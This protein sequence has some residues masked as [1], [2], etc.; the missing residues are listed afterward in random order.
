MPITRIG[1][2]AASTSMMSNSV[3]AVERVEFDLAVAPDLRLDGVHLARREHPRHQPAIGGVARRIVEDHHARRHLDV[4]LDQ[5]EDRAVARDQPA[6]ILQRRLDVVPTRD[7]PE[8]VLLVVVERLLVAHPLPHGIRI[9]VDLEV[10]RV[11]V[12]VGGRRGHVRNPPRS[13]WLG[14]GTGGR[15]P[16]PWR[17]A[18]RRDAPASTISSSSSVS[19][20]TS[21]ATPMHKRIGLASVQVDDDTHEFPSETRFRWRSGNTDRFPFGA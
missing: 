16:P 4:G 14:A 10:V 3:G 21:G 20:N 9:G 7:R 15:L 5:L 17:A 18:I 8:V 11:V 12:E 1:I 2:F 6:V 19:S 13:R